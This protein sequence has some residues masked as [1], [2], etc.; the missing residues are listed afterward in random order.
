MPWKDIQPMDQKILFISD[1]L[2][3]TATISDLCQRYGISRKTGC[4][5]LD[6]YTQ[7]GARGLLERSRTPESHPAKTP[8]VVRQ[9]IIELRTQ[10]RLPPG[11]KKIRTLLEEHYP[12]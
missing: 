10:L 9:R 11:A 8:Y 2:R 1:Y 6:R 12:E 5:R 4:K 3:R 7:Q